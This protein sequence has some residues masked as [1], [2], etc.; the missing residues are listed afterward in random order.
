MSLKSEG[1][2]FWVNILIRG[3]TYLGGAKLNTYFLEQF[4]IIKKGE[5]VNL[6]ISLIDFDDNKRD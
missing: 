6:N 3:S 5:I 4:V 2:I 1:H